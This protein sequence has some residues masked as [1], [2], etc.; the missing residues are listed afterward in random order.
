MKKNPKY[1]NQ[2]ISQDR[3]KGKLN[4]YKVGENLIKACGGTY[5][6]ANFQE[7][8]QQNVDIW[9]YSPKKGKLGIDVKGIK[10][11]HRS[12]DDSE[13]DDTIHWLE[14]VNTQGKKGWIYGKMDYIAFM[15]KTKI[16]FIK[17]E[18]L[19]GMIL[20]GV[21]GKDISL[22]NNNL[23]FYQPYRRKNRNDIIIKVPSADLEKIS[24]FTILTENE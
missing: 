21:V 12:D 19:Y 22:E 18:N 4:E 8:T 3:I 9:W 5:E 24:A 14:I 23:P 15:M 1:V 6:F 17:P 7:D 16:L 11:H 10:K 2:C 20:Y 13:I